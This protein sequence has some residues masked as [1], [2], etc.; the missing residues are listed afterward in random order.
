ML[1]ANAPSPQFV[2]ND[3][4]YVVLGINAFQGNTQTVKLNYRDRVD[5]VNILGRTRVGK[6][7]LMH[8]MIHQDIL[9]G[10]SVGVIDPHGSLVEDILRSSIPE[11]REKE[12]ILLDVHDTDYPVALNLL[13]APP[14]VPTSEVA[15]QT[16]SVIRKIFADYWSPT[17]MET[18]LKVAL[19][20]L[21]VDDDSTIMDVPRLL[22]D[23]D[24]RAKFYNE[25]TD[26]MAL[27]YWLYQYEPATSQEKINIAAPIMHRLSKFYEDLSL[28]NM[29][30][31]QTSLDF[32]RMLDQRTIFLANLGG[33]P[34]V[35]AETFGAMLIS[36]LQIA[37]MSREKLSRGQLAPFFLYIDEVQNFSTT[38]LP[39]LFSGAG[40]YGLSLVVANQYLRQLE[41]ETLGAVL[42][43]AGTSI[44]FRLGPQDAPVI[45]PFVRPYF[46]SSDLESMGR[47]RAVVKMQINA[48]A[49]PAFNIHTY[50]PPPDYR[51]AEARIER[52]RSYSRAQYAQKR[53]DVE[54]EINKRLLATGLLNLEAEDEEGEE[55][56]LG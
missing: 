56:Y 37:A 28:R 21:L 30:C 47:F 27:Q 16:V 9:A 8:H 24:F 51:D 46:T 42:G 11:D 29:V 34:D 35:E 18:V 40:K 20:T 39:V 3:N 45:A 25:K 23:S 7:T 36:K 44:I 50:A 43:N 17:R 4:E 12:V 5:H 2:F 14:N 10:K 41:G 49:V 48:E 31:Q 33:M 1:P 53:E 15:N 6:S 22:H 54:R 52:I 13:K 19:L 38:S 32:S 55:S 26:P